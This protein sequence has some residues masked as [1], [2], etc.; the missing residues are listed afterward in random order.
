MKDRVRKVRFK[1]NGGLL[2]TDTP[3]RQVWKIL[4]DELT[5]NHVTFLKG[6]AARRAQS[7][8]HVTPVYCYSYVDDPDGI[9]P[10]EFNTASG[11]LPRIKRT[12]K[13]HGYRV[14]VEDNTPTRP[15]LFVPRMERIR[16]PVDFRWGQ[17]G[18]LYQI[19]THNYGRIRCPTGYGKSML[20]RVLCQLLPH[21]KIAVA[22][23]SKDVLEQLYFEIAAAIPGVGIVTGAKKNFGRRITCY[24]GKSLHHAAGD[25]DLLLVDEGHEWGTQ[26]YIERVARFKHARRFMF[27]AS[28][29]RADGAHFE[30]EGA[31]GD[32]IVDISYQDAVDHGCIVPIE[33]RMKDVV[34]DENPADG[35]DDVSKERWGIWRNRVRN[36]I[37][38]ETVHEYPNL[39]KLVMVNTI[40]HA[41]F[42]KKLLPEAT[43]AYAEDGMTSDDR[44]R[45]IAWN[46][47]PKDEPVMTRERRRWLKVE[48]ERGNLELVIS[49]SVWKRG[50]DFKNLP[51]LIRGDAQDSAIADTQIP[52]RVA[53]LPGE[54]SE[55]VTPEKEVGLVIDL[56]D[57]FDTGYHRKANRRVHRYKEFGWNVVM[58]AARPSRFGQ[59]YL[60]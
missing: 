56:L 11:F 32:L 59:R 17:E 26:D 2:S 10:P 49:N 13:Q 24:S 8:V 45:Y 23:H 9:L 39:Q 58:P 46:L 51:V 28:Q 18:V 52:G 36:E 50:V 37:I 22:T 60:F 12:L 15:E 42:L 20:I 27:S 31:F 14:V 48:F 1:R 30:L 6:Q 33:V 34:M 47:L 7:N 35:K 43:L 19:L 54:V 29:E 44:R 57:Q 38:A 53:R 21:A 40:E 5:Y 16:P 25:E 41:C 4:E 55:G 3:N